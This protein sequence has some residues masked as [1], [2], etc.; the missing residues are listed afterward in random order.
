[1]VALLWLELDTSRARAALRR[2]LFALRSAVGDGFVVSTEQ[3]LTLSDDAVWSDVE[4]FLRGTEPG[5]SRE[6]AGAAI[7]LYRGDFLQGFSL[8]EAPSFDEW[9]LF[10]AE[11][12]RNRAVDALARI[13]EDDAA[14]GETHRALESA[15]R[16]LRLEPLH[17]AAHYWIMELYVRQGRRHL[18][19]E[20]FERYQRMLREQL[21]VA[22]P[23]RVVAYGNDVRQQMR[24]SI[25]SSR[26]PWD[27]REQWGRAIANRAWGEVSAC[28][29]SMSQ[30]FDE[31]GRFEEGA[32]L[33]EAAIETTDDEPLGGRLLLRLGTL[34]ASHGRLQEAREVLVRGLSIV[35]RCDELR[36]AA[37]GF[38][39]L[40]YVAFAL[41]RRTESF[42]YL[43]RSVAT[44][45]E[46]DDASGLAWS[47]N[48]LGHLHAEIGAVSE[49]GPFL[50]ESLELGCTIGD[51][52]R[53]GST[54]NSLGKAALRA[55][56]LELAH[57][58]LEQGLRLRRRLDHRIGIADS[59][60]NLADVYRASEDD[61]SA[62]KHY[63]RALVSALEIE[64]VPL[65][66]E[67][68]VSA[69]DQLRDR[70]ELR[71]ATELL[72]HARHHPST[73]WETKRRAASLLSKLQSASSQ[74]DF[75][76]AV[77]LGRS[78][79]HT[80]ASAHVL[81]SGRLQG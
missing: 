34:K 11:R 44:F 63:G 33:I 42:H 20:Q 10:E 5:A 2:T 79:T 12:L 57:G 15:R 54:F 56:K 16:L 19:A 14:T 59:L 76:A 49:A 25:V 74:D 50:D 53:V 4:V 37:G 6:S 17:E 26:E 48:V 75:R 39:R 45:R 71:P 24:E 70:N 69:G 35:R 67:V 22:P 28:L 51:R 41:G 65:V 66:M 1:M 47:L 43:E 68:F 81:G 73:W 3:E 30:A 46:L 18:A 40:G 9:Q 61:A 27:F 64:A 80:E 29:D 78:M 13:V 36:E 58:F 62:T 52:R 23:E 55:R 72:S 7:D 60:N 31:R 21:D 77:S 38:N 8:R 32:R